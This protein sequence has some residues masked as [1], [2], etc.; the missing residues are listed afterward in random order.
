MMIRPDQGDQKFEIKKKKKFEIKVEQCQKSCQKLRKQ[1]L[2]EK[3]K[4]VDNL[5]HKNNHCEPSKCCPNGDKSP[6]WVTL[7]RP[8]LV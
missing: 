2:L 1:F 3:R 7:I 8:L 6:N 5:G 4:I